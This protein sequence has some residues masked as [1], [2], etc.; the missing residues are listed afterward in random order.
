MTYSIDKT[1]ETIT[2]N[3][4]D[5]DYRNINILIDFKYGFKIS[6]SKLTGSINVFR[7]V[8]GKANMIQRMPKTFWTWEEVRNNYKKLAPVL[9]EVIELANQN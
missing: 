1:D 3:H 9:N 8:N 4:K 6:I 5:Y 2:V 7:T